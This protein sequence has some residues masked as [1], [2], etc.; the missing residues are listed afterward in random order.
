MHRLGI[1]PSSQC[2]PNV[3]AVNWSTC[4]IA[5]SYLL[6]G[7]AAFTALAVFL[8]IG[9]FVYCIVCARNSTWRAKA[10][11][12]NSAAVIVA[13]RYSQVEWDRMGSENS[14]TIDQI[15]SNFRWTRDLKIRNA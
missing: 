5:F 6:A 2:P 13:S 15:D 8:A 10:R 12:L 1:P 9:C 4:R 14:S 7:A 11:Q 3:S